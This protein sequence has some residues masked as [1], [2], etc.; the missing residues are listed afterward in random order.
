MM[1]HDITYGDSLTDD[2]PL[3]A[4]DTLLARRFRLWR[5]P[6]GRRQVYSVYPVEDAPDY[7][8][9]VA[10]AVRSE[11]GRCVPLWSGP[12]GAKARLMARVMGAQEIHLRIL[13]ETESGSLAPS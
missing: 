12:A 1:T 9:A 13:P 8:D 3:R 4:A 5:G 10:M 2:G 7:P 11:N 6:D